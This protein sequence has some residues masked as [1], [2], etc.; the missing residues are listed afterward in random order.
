MSAVPDLRILADNVSE[1]LGIFSFYMPSIH[2]NLIVKLLSDRFGIQV[3]GGCDCAGT[4][5]HYLLNLSYDE[6][7]TFTQKII[8]KDQSA[9][10]GWV[11]LS[12]HPTST[13]KDVIFMADSL[14][15]IRN[16][17][18]VWSEDYTYNKHT[19]EFTHK[20]GSEGYTRAESF[21]AMNDFVD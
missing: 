5:G 7:K 2:Y 1:R 17:Y 11:R 4:Y 21:F 9:K 8:H 6:S 16:N 12:F 18:K 13:D 15:Q 20:A 3:R 14:K 10:P 19:N